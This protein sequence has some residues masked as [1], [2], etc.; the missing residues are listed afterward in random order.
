MTITLKQ[1]QIVFEKE[2]VD[3][4]RTVPLILFTGKPLEKV[5]KATDTTDPSVY[6]HPVY[7]EIVNWSRNVSII[8]YWISYTIDLI[9]EIFTK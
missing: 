7:V 3:E 4:A 1:L 5:D 6:D 2:L 9:N 8:H